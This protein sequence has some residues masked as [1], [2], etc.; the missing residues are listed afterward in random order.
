RASAWHGATAGDVLSQV[1]TAILR[2]GQRTFCTA[3]YC[4]LVP[5]SAG[6]RFSVAA[7]GHPLPLVR[8]ADGKCET[9]GE[10]GTLLGMLPDSRSVTES[11]VLYPED[12]VV[13]YTDGVTDLAPP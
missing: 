4:E 10:P 8:R 11:T 6:V 9:F 13:L 1:N 7:G 3:L 2:C 12:L 5:E